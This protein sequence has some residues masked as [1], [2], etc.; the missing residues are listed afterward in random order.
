MVILFTEMEKDFGDLQYIR[1]QY[2]RGQWHPTP[3]LLPG[4]SMDRGAW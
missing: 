2:Q 4:K 3:V 1:N